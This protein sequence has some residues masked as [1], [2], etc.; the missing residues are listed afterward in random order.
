M[1]VLLLFIIMIKNACLEQL[2]ERSKNSSG[3]V[4]KPIKKVLHCCRNEWS[5]DTW[6]ICDLGCV[7]EHYNKQTQNPHAFKII[8]CAYTQLVWLT[9]FTATV[10]LGVDLSLI[11][12]ISFSLMILIL[13]I[14]L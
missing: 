13:K 11:I 6:G 14:A 8:F 1:E 3:F 2:A 10:L 7:N 12:G 4:C 9:V 5:E